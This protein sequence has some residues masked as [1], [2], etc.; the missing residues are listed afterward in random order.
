MHIKS[1]DYYENL[2]TATEWYLDGVTL[3]KINLII[4]KNATGKTRLL[5]VIYGLANLVSNDLKFNF[6]SGKYDILFD[7]NNKKT[8]YILEYNDIKINKEELI[9]DGKKLLS[10]GQEGKGEIFAVQLGQNMQFQ[11]PVNELACVVRR[12]SV[13]HPFFEDIFHW[14]KETKLYRFGTELGRS[15]L[16]VF[17]EKKEMEEKLNH[18]ETEQVVGFLKKGQKKWGDDFVNSIKSDMNYVGYKL[19]DVG[20][21]PF[22]RA[23]LPDGSHP[24]G[25]YVQE[26][27]LTGKTFQVDMSQ[28]M[29]RVLSLL[30][31][32]AYSKFSNSATCILIDDIG[33]GLDYDRSS[34]L[35]KLLVDK[36]KETNIQ[37]IMSTNDRF[38]MNNVPLEYWSILKRTGPKCITLNIRNA[39]KIFDDFNFTGLSNFD[40]FSTDFYLNGLDE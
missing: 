10:R 22:E 16:V 11:A 33:E 19:D 26:S 21:A 35:I 4:G 17:L 37:L 32:I 39:K 3:E 20:I 28:G 30:A 23:T 12:D 13:Q 15:N 14:G 40:F 31:Q 36:V 18:K 8:Q 1:I 7:K 6:T 2:N 38:V 29:F 27:D 24:F 5:S 25:I 34:T 9:V